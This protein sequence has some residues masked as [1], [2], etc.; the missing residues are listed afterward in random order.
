MDD[1]RKLY[2]LID[3]LKN[4]LDQLEKENQDLKQLMENDKTNDKNMEKIQQ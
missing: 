4:Q 3:E 2:D 1:I